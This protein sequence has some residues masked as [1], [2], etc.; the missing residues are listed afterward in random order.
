[1]IEARVIGVMGFKDDELAKEIS[2]PDV[3]PWFIVE[4]IVDD[5]R[6][7]FVTKNGKS[8]RLLYQLPM[9]TIWWDGTDLSA[10]ESSVVKKAIRS[11]V[12]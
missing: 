12:N 5:R 9:L 4:M 1:M 3:E 6:Q 10:K 7:K 2:D 11:Y 8:Y